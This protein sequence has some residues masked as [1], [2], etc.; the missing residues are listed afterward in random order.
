MRSVKLGRNSGVVVPALGLGTWRFGESARTR[1]AEVAAVRSALELGYRLIDTAE[2]YGDGGAE[3]VVGK[4][5]AEAF[6]AG[7]LRREEVFVVTKVYPHNATRR[8]V[9]AACDR[10]RARLQ[11]DHIDL[12]LLHWRGNHPLA[13][14]IAG[15]EALRENGLIRHWGVSNFDVDDLTELWQL[16]AG[17]T[18]VTNQ[19]Y[20]SATHRG[21]E[22]D[23]LPWQRERGLSTMAYS[24]IDQGTLAADRGLARLA[25]RIGVT[26]PQLALAWVLRQPDVIAIPKAARVEHLSA[27]LAAASLAVDDDVCAAIDQ[28]FPAPRRKQP[29]AIT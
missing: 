27:N 16:E 25:A 6:A 24:P 20:Y 14:T 23:L 3:Q 17:A 5:L 12:Y 19:V 1:A 13:Q 22:F 18:C 15:F 28:L 11:L 9:A 29:L 4:A 21:I 10:S 8:G 2:M 7:A 26:A